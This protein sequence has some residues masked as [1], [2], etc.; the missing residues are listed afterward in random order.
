MGTK[1]TK[2]SLKQMIKEELGRV[3]NENRNYTS[4]QGAKMREFEND[5]QH[6]K[7][8][9]QVARK[10]FYNQRY[11]QGVLTVFIP[12]YI[13]TRAKCAAEGGDRRACENEAY[14]AAWRTFKSK[15]LK[16]S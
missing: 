1:L 13:D 12:T 8:A 10:Y 7:R 14:F 16:V 4:E 9:R 11:Y 15:V 6:S 2:E 3:L 5:P